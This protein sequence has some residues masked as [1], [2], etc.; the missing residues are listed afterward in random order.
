MTLVLSLLTDDFIIHASDR[1]LTD[2]RTGRQV[3]TKAAKTVICPPLRA[4]VSFRCQI[5]SRSLAS[6]KPVKRSSA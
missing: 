6:R 5:S 1:R 3:T 2:G 4:M